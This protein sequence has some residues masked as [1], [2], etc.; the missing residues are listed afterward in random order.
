MELFVLGINKSE[1]VVLMLLVERF[2]F[3]VRVVEGDPRRHIQVYC[4]EAAEAVRRLLEVI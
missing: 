4:R 2:N 3:D 1:D